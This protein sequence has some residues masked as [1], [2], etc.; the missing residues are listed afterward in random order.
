MY[1]FSFPC[2]LRM[3]PFAFFM[4]ILLFRSS[5][6]ANCRFLRFFSTEPDL[7]ARF[8]LMREHISFRAF[9]AEPKMLCARSFCG[10]LCVCRRDSNQSGFAVVKRQAA[11][12]IP[13]S[14]EHTFFLSFVRVDVCR[15]RQAFPQPRWLPCANQ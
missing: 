4:D 5:Q 9:S 10:R 7:H 1:D 3:I 2:D 11:V 15:S 14:L 8:A 12:G 13:A 6:C